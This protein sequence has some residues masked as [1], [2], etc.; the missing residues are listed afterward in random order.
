MIRAQFI[1]WDGS[2]P[3]RGRAARSPRRVLISPAVDRRWRW[4]WRRRAILAGAGPLM[5]QVAPAALVLLARRSHTTWSTRRRR[6]RRRT[7]VSLDLGDHAV[8]LVGRHRAHPRRSRRWAR[9]RPS[10]PRAARRPGP[11]TK[12][13]TRSASGAAAGAGQEAAPSTWW[14]G[15]RG[16]PAGPPQRVDHLESFVEELGVP[17][18]RRARRTRR[19]RPRRDA[20]ADAQHRPATGQVVD[21]GDLPGQ[22][23]RPPPGDG[24]DQCAHAHPPS[25]WPR[26]PARS[27][28]R[29][30]GRRPGSTRTWSHR[31]NPSQPPAFGGP[32]ES[33]RHDRLG[34]VRDGESEAHARTLRIGHEPYSPHDLSRPPL[35]RRPRR[36]QRRVPAGGRRG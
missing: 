25:P 2:R 19:T 16:R 5:S 12:H 24:R 27:T 14:G 30:P 8:D 9:H 10:G 31:K 36:G 35:L 26:P 15:R 32:G 28:A 22:H 23:P 6:R 17:S 34:E 33:S 21:G 4:P 20:Q 13:P 3:E 7:A 18:G 29:S 1:D 11:A